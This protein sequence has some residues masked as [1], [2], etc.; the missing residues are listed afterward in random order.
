MKN[1]KNFT[2]LYELSKTLR[3]E[4]RPVGET[5]KMLKENKVFDID[6]NI[7]KKY[8][9]TKPFFDR[10]HRK[11]VKEALSNIALEGLSDYLET[12]KKFT[13]DRKDKESQKELE[14]QEKLLRKQIKIFFDSQANQWKEKYNK[15]NFKKS[16]LNILFEE[17]I[18][19]LLKE[20]YG[21]EY[22]AF[23]KNDDKEFIFEF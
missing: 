16:G 9:A 7:K 5:T 21:K 4:L 22:D 23:L 11:F 12:Y 6:E 2:N 3:F 20:I 10:L 18:L 13:N 17:S 1:F 8:E 14:K 19:Q 15:I